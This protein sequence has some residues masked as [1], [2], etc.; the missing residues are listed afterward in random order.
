MSKG[1]V[2][3]RTSVLLAFFL[4]VLSQRGFSQTE[5][6]V[7]LTAATASED[8]GQDYAPWLDDDLWHKVTKNWEKTNEKY[9]DVTLRL[10]KKTQLS[11]LSLYDGEDVFK[12]NPAYIFA[13]DGGTRTYLGTFDGQQYQAWVDL[14]ASGI[15][16]DAILISKYGNNFPEKINV[17][18][19]AVAAAPA[20]APS[21]DPAPAPVPAPVPFPT[22][23]VPAKTTKSAN[24]VTI[25]VTF[26]QAPGAASSTFTDLKYGKEA[27]FQFEVDDNNDVLLPIADYLAHSY[28]RPTLTDGCG[29]AVNYR[30]AAAVNS[31]SNFNNGDYGDGRY[32]GKVTWPQLAAFVRDGNALENHGLYHDLWGNYSFS[33]DAAR[34]LREN[35]LNVYAQLKQSGVEYRMRTVVRPN[36]DNGYVRAADEAGYLAASSEPKDDSYVKYPMELPT[37]DVQT[38]PGGFVHL[39]RRFSDLNDWT[40]LNG[41]KDNIGKMLAGSNATTHQLFRLGTHVAPFSATQYLFDYLHSVAGDRVWVTHMDELMEYLEVKRQVVKSEY[42]NYNKLTITLDYGSVPAINRY[43][44]LSLRISGGAIQSVM[45]S[46]ADN[47]S[48]N[49]SSGLVNVFKQNTS[50]KDPAK[51]WETTTDYLRA[52]APA[53]AEVKELQLSAYPNP[54]SSQ[55]TVQFAL[56]QAGLATLDLLD[57]DGRVVRHLFAGQAPAGAVQRLPL[58]REGLSQKLYIVRLVTA[59]KV[60]T[61]KLVLAQ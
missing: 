19:A 23:P 10:E 36:S 16:A 34:N 45:V 6:R 9:V 47:S 33:G 51:D 53:A 1:T 17:F 46:G 8:T 4:F 18:G 25:E 59:H 15:M 13:L 24:L 27:V 21:P 57:L 55:T 2:S 49:R 41:V 54:F 58:S 20:W 56:P 26:D 14:P 30:L 28:S 7:K 11:R 43:R 52:A 48:F 32:S 50:F 42:L 60:L 5:E 38:L 29:N 12:K 61:Q 22:P 44:D 3:S 39:G 40:Q 37:V 31:R 35:L